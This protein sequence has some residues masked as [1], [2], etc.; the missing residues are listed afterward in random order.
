MFP[1]HKQN[2]VDQLKTTKD[3]GHINSYFKQKKYKEVTGIIRYTDGSVL[4]NK[5]GCGVHTVQGKRVIYN[6][7][8]YLG[9][10]PTVFQAEVT[11]IKKSAEMLLNKQMEKQ[12]IQL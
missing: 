9:N 7:H 11:A 2:I 4:E 5:T 10:S 8:F 12:N 3:F 1:N 6:G